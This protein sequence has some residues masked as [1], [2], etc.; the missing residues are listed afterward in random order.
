MS[1]VPELPDFAHGSADPSSMADAG[2]PPVTPE[3]ESLL[4]RVAVQAVMLRA[5]TID[6]ALDCYTPVYFAQRAREEIARRQRYGHK[7]SLLLLAPD[8]PEGEAPPDGSMRVVVDAAKSI[9]RTTDLVGRWDLGEIGVLLPSTNLAG[10]TKLARRILDRLRRRPQPK[11]SEA[12]PVL[13]CAGIATWLGPAE[14]L[15]TLIERAR[16]GLSDAKARGGD[17]IGLS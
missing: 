12:P 7:L 6:S 10:A 4:S 8:A 9:L 16:G 15:G 14:P 17:S 3:T 13:A 5:A 11:G 1:S 2:A